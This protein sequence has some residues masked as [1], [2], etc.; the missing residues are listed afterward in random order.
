MHWSQHNANHIEENHFK[1]TM[2]I[3]DLMME[4]ASTSETAVNLILPDYTV[5]HPRRQSSSYSPS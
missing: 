5:Q 3:I 1:G 2:T 4:A